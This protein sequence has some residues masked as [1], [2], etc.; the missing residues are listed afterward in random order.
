MSGESAKL[1]KPPERGEHILKARLW[2][3]EAFQNE[4]QL[5]G[6][7]LVWLLPEELPLFLPNLRRDRSTHEVDIRFYREGN[8]HRADNGVIQPPVLL[9]SSHG[10]ILLGDPPES[11]MSQFALLN[12]VVAH[13]PGANARSGSRTRTGCRPA[14]RRRRASRLRRF[15]RWLRMTSS[16]R[17]WTT[18]PCRRRRRAHTEQPGWSD[19]RR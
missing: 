4:L 17:R 11:A 14:S 6:S 8:K 16:P 15:H 13:P 2:E 1:S 19:C 5:A 3:S 12:E 10:C 7:S 9:P 18:V